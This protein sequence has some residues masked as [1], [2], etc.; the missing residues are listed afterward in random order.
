MQVALPAPRD[1]ATLPRLALVAA[2][3]LLLWPGLQLTEFSPAVLF[4]AR[5]REVMGRFLGTFFPPDLSWPFL[6]LVLRSTVETLAIA[7]A[8]SF[9]A[10]VV[11]FPLSLVVSRSLAISR[12]G[13]RA[14]HRASNLVRLPA[15][16]LLVFLRSIPEVVWALLLV[17]ALGLGP[18]AGMLAIAINYSGMLGKVYFEIYE[19]GDTRPARALMEAGSGRVAAFFYGIFPVAV[20]EMVSYS[21]YRWECAVRASVV[22]GY[23]GAGG[24]G[25]QM[26]LSMRTLNGAEVS[27]ILLAFFLL[28]A[29]ADTISWLLRRRLG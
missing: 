11:A 21:V 22:M 25:T 14:G 1:P 3:I 20:P 6:A 17:R 8:G 15:R 4:D 13:P 28:V 9:L 7:T 2:A 18:A 23:V 27:T 12:I 5:S 24:L 29:L 19:A 26:E 10:I 16:W